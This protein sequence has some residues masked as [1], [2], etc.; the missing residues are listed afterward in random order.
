[1]KLEKWKLIIGCMIG[2]AFL[3]GVAYTALVLP[4]QT[5]NK[6]YK[7]EITEMTNITEIHEHPTEIISVVNNITNNK[8]SY[9]IHY[10]PAHLTVEQ[11]GECLKVEN[12][13]DKT[14]I[15]EW[16]EE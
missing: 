6:E 5:I 4:E 8:T 14:I 7:T 9:T 13:T 2:A 3:I 15:C 11:I 10:V 12:T 1:M 16:W